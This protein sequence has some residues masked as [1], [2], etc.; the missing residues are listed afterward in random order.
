MRPA[1]HSGSERVGIWLQATSGRDDAAARDR[2]LAALS[3]LQSGETFAVMISADTIYHEAI[4]EWNGYPKRLN[5][6]G[7]PD[8][9]GRVY[10]TGF[11]VDFQSP[12]KVSSTISGYYDQPY[13]IFPDVDFTLTTTDTLSVSGG[14]VKCQS[15]EDF[16]KDTT[17]LHILTGAFLGFYPPLGLVYGIDD[18][19][20]SAT[21]APDVKQ[22]SLGCPAAIKYFKES[23]MIPSGFNVTFT[24]TRVTASWTAGIV[25]GGKIF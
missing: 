2:G 16:D 24:Y 6:D 14:R 8:P 22:G 10:L 4:N 1:C 20:A 17:W 23:I 21:D 12:N 18:I 3:L 15:V 13:W 25:A 5:S 11:G 9:N 7:K 19:I